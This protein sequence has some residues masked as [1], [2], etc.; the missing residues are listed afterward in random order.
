M[1]SSAGS[2]VSCCSG[3]LAGV[4]GS[5]FT[6]KFGLPEGVESKRG[7]DLLDKYFGGVGAGQSGSIVIHTPDGSV[8]DPAVQPEVQAYLDAVA[9]VDGVAQVSSPYNEA[10]QRQ[11][12]QQGDEAGKIAYATIAFPSD[13][14]RTI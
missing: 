8:T 6:S 10:G 7:I 12:A 9:G 13:A 1:S 11:I 14:P 3:A 4:L 5:G 2:S